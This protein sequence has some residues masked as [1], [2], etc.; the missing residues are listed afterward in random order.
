[1]P[2]LLLLPTSSLPS[3]AHPAAFGHPPVASKGFGVQ[4][5]CLC[6]CNVTLVRSCQEGYEGHVNITWHLLSSL[7]RGLRGAVPVPALQVDLGQWYSVWWL[8]LVT[9]T[10]CRVK[11]WRKCAQSQLWCDCEEHKTR[12][13]VAWPFT[14][15]GG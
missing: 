7:F 2:V 1:M 8:C 3:H 10:S 12:R 6:D 4:K 13:R 9:N 14:V 5:E 11:R 15:E